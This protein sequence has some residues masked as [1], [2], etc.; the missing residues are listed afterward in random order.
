MAETCQLFADYFSTV[1][2]N[3]SN[4][5]DIVLPPL[6]ALNNC[7]ELTAED[8]QNGLDNL[9]P[10]LSCGLDGVPAIVLSTCSSALC[11]PLLYLFNRSLRTGMVPKLWKM[12]AVMPIHKSG[13]RRLVSNYRSISLQPCMGKLL[14]QL[15][16]NS[17]SKYVHSRLSFK[18]HGFIGGRSTTT[19]LMEFTD[20]AIRTIE[21]GYQLDTF[22]ADFS[23][24]FDR[25]NHG[26]LIK[27]LMSF[28]LNDAIILWIYSYLSDRY[29]AVK[30]CD[31]VSDLYPVK[32]GVPQG[33]HIGPL[34]FNIFINDV[35]D[36]F[37]PD[38]CLLFADDLK[39]YRR[40]IDIDDC[41]ELQRSIVDLVA[42]CNLNKI[43]LNSDK[44]YIISFGRSR[45]PILFDYLL[46]ISPVSR[47]HSIRDL[48]V[49]LDVKLTFTEHFNH[50]I[51]KAYSM[52]GFILRICKEFTDPFALKSLYV[53][54]VRPILEYGSVVW[55]PYYAVHI[56]RIESIQKRFVLAALRNLGWQSQFLLPPYRDRLRLLSMNSLE[57]RRRFLKAMFVFDVLSS[58]ID[59]PYIASSVTTSIP[60]RDLRRNAFFRLSSHRT[61]YGL[62]NPLSSARRQFNSVSDLFSNNT[63]RNAFKISCLN[64]LIAIYNL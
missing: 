13:S 11:D 10:S 46:S 36:I 19:N 14:E 24:A 27:K 38:S 15:V 39:L 51:N 41:H 63:N 32:S 50:I 18:Q 7:T 62:N 29:Q 35:V 61:N 52:L 47:Q 45:S 12:S 26:I 2:A 54:L 16:Q 55:S 21:D 53:A 59:S 23:K 34:L 3:D 6:A 57:L 20:V 56:S 44:C 28:G 9:K 25:V 64:S 31:T 37:P 17:L 22:Y 8:V 43:S 58:K 48:G 5:E 49:I 42:W 60:P 30:I 40:I 33:S 4:V 1:Y